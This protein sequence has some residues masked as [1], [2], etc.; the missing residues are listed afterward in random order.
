LAVSV[1]VIG[2]LVGPVLLAYVGV[3]RIGKSLAPAKRS[4][5]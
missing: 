2:L 1:L 4:R 3:W 5:D